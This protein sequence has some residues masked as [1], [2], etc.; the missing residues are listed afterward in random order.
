[1][2]AANSTNLS[3]DNIMTFFKQTRARLPNATY[4]SYKLYLIPTIAIKVTTGGVNSCLGFVGMYESNSGEVS[5]KAETITISGSMAGF[6]D[7]D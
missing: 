5:V 6:S 7:L 3:F 2:V 1:M 4:D